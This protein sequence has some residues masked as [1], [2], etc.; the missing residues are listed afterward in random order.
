M[1]LC[2]LLLA[3]TILSAC[4]SS[5]GSSHG[6]GTTPPPPPPPP[7]ITYIDY[8][9]SDTPGHT[10]S[11]SIRPTLIREYSD[12]TWQIQFALDGHTETFNPPALP[13]TSW[14]WT[15]T[16]WSVDSSDVVHVFL[17][18]TTASGTPDLSCE[19]LLSPI[20]SG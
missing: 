2:T 13:D 7:P 1:R 3:I 17:D 12:G 10:T 4:G 16:V 6:G 11:P 8:A 19:W 18:N 15:M 9:P 20:G 14:G 5:G